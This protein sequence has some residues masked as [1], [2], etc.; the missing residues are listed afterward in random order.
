MVAELPVPGPPVIEASVVDTPVIEVGASEFQ[1]EI[2]TP[3]GHRISV[4]G[5]Y[6]PDALCRLV[7][8]GGRVH[9]PRPEQ[10]A[11]LDGCLRDGYAARFYYAGGAG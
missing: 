3:T 7:W 9:G 11:D 6:D 8:W 10:R 2:V 4:S 1:I 5:A